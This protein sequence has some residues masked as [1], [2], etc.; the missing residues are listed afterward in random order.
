MIDDTPLETAI[1][2]GKLPGA[3]AMLSTRDG[4]T[5]ARAFGMADATTGRAMAIDT[6]FQIASMTK[7]V[8]SVGAMQLVERGL[9][10]LDAPIGELLPDLASPQVLASFAADGTPELRP[11]SRPV[12]LRHLLTHTSGLG[13]GFVQPE[14]LRWFGHAGMAAPGSHAAITMPLL[15]D[16][17]ERWEYSVATDWAGLAIEAATGSALGAYLAEHV[18]EPLGMASTGF[19]PALPTEASQVHVRTPDGGLATIAMY[20]GGGEFDSGGGGLVSTAPDYTR[21]VRT[22]LR[23]GELDGARILTPETMAEMSRNQVAPLKAGAV[24]TAMPEL[25]TA[26]DPFPEQHSG[27]GLGFLINPETGRD[28][29][30]A[31]S[32]SWAGIFNSYYW[33]DPKADVAGVFMAQVA[34]FAD[35]GALAAYAALEQMA[36]A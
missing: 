36:Y 4:E 26:F 9:L 25:A 13:Y 33:I 10:A 23:G 20:L 6:P 8:V 32:L 27:W 18:F 15:F 5:Y 16:P 24:G 12:T 34:P 1:A 3:V 2:Q 17:G 29:R 30:S 31:G 35:A 11:A 21:F 28:G 22:I 7:A 19:L 14:I